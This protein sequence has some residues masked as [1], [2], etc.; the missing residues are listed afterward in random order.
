MLHCRVTFFMRFACG[1]F[2]R[3]VHVS[4]F[5]DPALI[6]PAHGMRRLPYNRGQNPMVVAESFCAREQINKSNTDQIRQF[7]I[8]NA[9]EDATSGDGTHVVFGSV[10]VDV[11]IGGDVWSGSAGL[12][13]GRSVGQSSRRVVGNLVSNS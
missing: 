2:V 11:V 5:L 4:T 3:C 13:V 9:G 7:I 1:V 12:S 8:Q 6:R 10:L